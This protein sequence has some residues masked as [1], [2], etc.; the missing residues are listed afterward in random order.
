MNWKKYSI[1]ERVFLGT[2]GDDG[3]AFTSL[4]DDDGIDNC[5]AG[6]VGTKPDFLEASSG[7]R[8]S[9]S[10]PS[11]ADVLKARPGRFL[12]EV[13]YSHVSSRLRHDAQGSDPEHLVFVRRQLVQALLVL[14]GSGF[15]P[16]METCWKSWQKE[17]VKSRRSQSA[18]GS[19]SARLPWHLTWKIVTS[20]VSRLVGV[21]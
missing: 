7:R 12:A 18:H 20:R 8:G 5:D 11:Q 21:A 19:P 3:C 4:V 9:I 6:D 10:A 15:S 16:S 1:R 14:R 13:A 2:P 17:Q